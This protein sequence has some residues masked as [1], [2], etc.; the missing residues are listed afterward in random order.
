MSPKDIWGKKSMHLPYPRALKKNK[1]AFPKFD[2][3]YYK[4]NLYICIVHYNYNYTEF[5]E[6]LQEPNINKNLNHIN[7]LHLDECTFAPRLQV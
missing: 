7:I 6:L 5:Y 4:T 2:N 1:A 3:L